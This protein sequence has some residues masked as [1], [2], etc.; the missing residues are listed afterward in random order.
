MDGHGHWIGVRID[1][2]SQNNDDAAKEFYENQ[3]NAGNRLV[4][5]VVVIILRKSQKLTMQ[6]RID[7]AAN[8]VKTF[9]IVKIL[10]KDATKQVSNSP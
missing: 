7:N 3:D 2:A 1:D 10:D 5:M 6:V 4:G 8:D 9:L